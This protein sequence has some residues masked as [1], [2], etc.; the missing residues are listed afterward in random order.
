MRQNSSDR[1]AWV[2][3]NCKRYVGVWHT[4][5]STAAL[6]V[7]QR[8]EKKKKKAHLKLSILL[9]GFLDELESF[10][11]TLLDKTLRFKTPLHYSPS[12]PHPIT[13]AV[14]EKSVNTDEL[15]I[16]CCVKNLKLRLEK[17]E[18]R[19][20]CSYTLWLQLHRTAT[21]G[22][23]EATTLRFRS[24][25]YSVALL[26]LLRWTT[27]FMSAAINRSDTRARPPSLPFFSLYLPP[28]VSSSL[29]SQWVGGRDVR[30]ISLFLVTL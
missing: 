1:K 25:M 22:V 2:N 26:P 16:Q 9:L 28:L 5:V 21:R 14:A 17:S 4:N 20:F 19:L 6:L 13:C 12:N 10:D 23:E 11:K 3:L 27:T 18:Y 15:L 29:C 7:Y 30:A 24:F 8:D